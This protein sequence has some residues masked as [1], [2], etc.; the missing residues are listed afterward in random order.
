ML[1]QMCREDEQGNVLVYEEFPM[2]LQQLRIDALHNALVETDVGALRI[3]LILLAR[4]MGLPSDNILPVWDLRKI[5]LA[6]DQLC[7]SRM[8]IH[9]ILSIVHPD[10]HGD[11]EFGYFLRVC[12]TVI[13]WMFDTNAFAEKAATIAK[14][15]ADA[16]AKQDR[17]GES[18]ELEELQGLSSSLANKKRGMD[19]D[20]MQR[21]AG[22]LF[23]VGRGFV[24]SRFSTVRLILLF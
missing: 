21:S 23:C 16:L 2:L 6:A 24:G 8:Q 1:M 12:C 13:P 17:M 7:L 20:G 10:E 14:E 4:R 9:V 15:K 11:V 19:E 18:L 3:H 22:L 5:L